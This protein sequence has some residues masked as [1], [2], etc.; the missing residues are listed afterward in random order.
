MKFVN[1]LDGCCK[2]FFSFCLFIYFNRPTSLYCS[3]INY[4]VATAGAWVLFTETPVCLYKVIREFLIGRLGEY[5]LFPERCNHQNSNT[6]SFGYQKHFAVPN[7]CKWPANTHA[8]IQTAE[9]QCKSLS[10]K[11]YLMSNDI[12]VWSFW[13]G[14]IFLRFKIQKTQYYRMKG[15]SLLPLSPSHPVF[16]PRGNQGGA[17]LFSSFRD[18]CAHKYL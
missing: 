18:I 8:R 5:D 16:L 9:K 7:V 6:H 12:C 3:C 4:V 1:W 17:F 13:I 14:N 2:L 15:I 10:I 11:E